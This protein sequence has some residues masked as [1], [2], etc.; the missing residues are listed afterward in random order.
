[1]TFKG[2]MDNIHYIIGVIGVLTL[3]FGALILFITG[4][5]MNIDKVTAFTTDAVMPTEVPIIG[6][7]TNNLGNGFI[8]I[9]L[10]IVIICAFNWDKI[11]HKF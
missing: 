1:M 11:R 9:L 7:I 5:Y 6:W 10:I 3:V 2:A 8:A 4:D